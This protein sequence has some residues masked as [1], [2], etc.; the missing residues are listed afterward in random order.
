MKMAAGFAV[1]VCATGLD[2]CVSAK[3]A[4]R[5]KVIVEPPIRA[6][7]LIDGEDVSATCFYADDEAGLVRL[8]LEKDKPVKGIVYVPPLEFGEPITVER[9]GTV[10]IEI[11]VV[12]RS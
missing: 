2:S 3:T 1:H 10:Q 11:T 12:V 7:V 4:E 8:Y 5:L 6:R 9:F